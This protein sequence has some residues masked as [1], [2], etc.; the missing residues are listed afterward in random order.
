ME[1]QHLNS[2]HSEPETQNRETPPNRV[3]KLMRPNTP[4]LPGA[5]ALM[6]APQALP[7][8][9]IPCLTEQWHFP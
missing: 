6:V 5:S 3:R 1:K 8:R 4:G 9:G 7:C 2:P